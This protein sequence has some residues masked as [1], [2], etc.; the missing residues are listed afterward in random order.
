M[1]TRGDVQEKV[2]FSVKS[3]P[4]QVPEGPTLTTTSIQDCCYQLPLFGKTGVTAPDTDRFKNDRTAFLK[5]YDSAV[6]AVSIILQKCVD[7]EFTDVVTLSDSTYGDFFDFTAGNPDFEG[8][9]NS[10]LT[11]IGVYMDWRQVLIDPDVLGT[12]GEGIYRLRTDETNILASLANQSQYSF[13]YNL[14]NFTAERANKTVRFGFENSGVLGFPKSPKERFQ[15]PDNWLDGIRIAGRFGN[16]FSEYDQEYTRYN[17]GFEQYLQNDQR[18]KFILETDRMP[19]SVHN[20]LK[21]EVLQA[22]IIEATDY[23]TD[24][25]NSHVETPIKK[26]N[27]YEPVW[28]KFSKLAK[29][30][31]EFESA[32]DNL[33][34]LHC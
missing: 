15:Y 4:N 9:D 1:A 17:N 7:D 31:V 21:S 19:E 23:N 11:Y 22:D 13:E 2:F 6:T 33:R 8:L 27:G 29:V 18:E 10:P 26:P 3:D 24:N 16:N 32:Y 14:R 25:A 5:A 28:S 30:T 20:F 12:L 34:K